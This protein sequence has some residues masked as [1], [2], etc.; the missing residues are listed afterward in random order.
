[1]KILIIWVSNGLSMV[2][3]L[4]VIILHVA[5]Q[6][7]RML[8]FTK[9]KIPFLVCLLFSFISFI[10]K[11]NI[12]T[13]SNGIF[14]ALVFQYF[15]HGNYFW[16]TS[17]SLDI[18]LTFRRIAN[19]IQ[20]EKKRKAVQGYK[21]R[22]YYIV[23][24][25]VPAIIAFVTGAIQ[26]A[27]SPEALPYI[28][29]RFNPCTGV[30][31][32]RTSLFIYFQLIIYTL[33]AINIF[34]YCHMAFN[35]TCGIWKSDLFGKYQLRNLAVLVELL[36][37][38]GIFNVIFNSVNIFYFNVIRQQLPDSLHSQLNFTILFFNNLRGVFILLLF[39]LK[40]NNRNL[41]KTTYNNLAGTSST[42]LSQKKEIV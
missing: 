15:Y 32:T 19:P 9:L 37:V 40:S 16:L 7:L 29:P 4:I 22:R 39:F 13:K 17:M 31:G 33:V 8:N 11:N 41:V 5:I 18:W 21:M 42:H 20:N 23:S 3:I 38:M 26:F 35:F 28:H 2:S 30:M 10:I 24:L 34:F 1:M 27:F 36:V 14:L 25:G 12:A 6:D